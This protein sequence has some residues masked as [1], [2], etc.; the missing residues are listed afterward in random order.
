MKNLLVGLVWNLCKVVVVC[1]LIDGCAWVWTQFDPT[2]T[3]DTALTSMIGG[4]V[5]VM[6]VE[7][8]SLRKDVSTLLEVREL[9][10]LMIEKLIHMAQQSEKT[11]QAAAVTSDAP[12]AKPRRKR[13]RKPA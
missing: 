5:A 2:L 4:V 7:I 9:H 10:S 3:P 6:V 1:A 11:P 12:Q 13:N 8:F